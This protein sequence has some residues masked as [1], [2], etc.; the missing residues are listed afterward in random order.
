ME[1]EFRDFLRCGS[2]GGGFARN[3]DT[4]RFHP[5]PPLDVADV[6][7]VLATVTAYVGR[8]LAQGGSGDGD[9]GGMLDEWVDEAPVLAGLAAAS[10]QGRV[11]LGV[12]GRRSRP[13][14]RRPVGR[15]YR[16]L[17]AWAVPRA[18]QRI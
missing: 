14:P 17:G 4:V 10:V 2:L 9:D 1:Q 5:C 3:G 18:P 11:E 12:A 6:D 15:R 8:L 7:E 16:A 13:P